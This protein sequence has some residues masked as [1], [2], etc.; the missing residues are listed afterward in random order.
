[1]SDKKLLDALRNIKG[2]RIYQFFLDEKTGEITDITSS[3]EYV[4]PIRC[5]DCEF[6]TCIE[7]EDDWWECGQDGRVMHS[8]GFC[9]WAERKEE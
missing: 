3:M 1:M 2:R 5:K 6:S 7:K 4:K 8:N 9:S